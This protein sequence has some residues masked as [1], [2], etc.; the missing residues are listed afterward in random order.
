M[1]DRTRSAELPSQ[2]D[3]TEESE[4]DILAD[5]PDDEP[6][7][8][9]LLIASSFNLS[10]SICHLCRWYPAF[11][12]TRHLRSHMNCSDSTGHTFTKHLFGLSGQN[13]FAR[14]GLRDLRTSTLRWSEECLESPL[15]GR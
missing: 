9:V 2:D 7:R 13:L 11:R 1:E 10:P 6:A 8:P 4:D 5:S 12:A 15:Y 3:S 14:P